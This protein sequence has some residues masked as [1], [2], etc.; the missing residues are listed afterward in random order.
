MKNKFRNLG[1]QFVCGLLILLWVLLVCCAIGCFIL[2]V[3]LITCLDFRMPRPIP[4]FIMG[5]WLSKLSTEAGEKMWNGGLTW[6]MQNGIRAFLKVVFSHFLV[7]LAAGVF[8]ILLAAFWSFIFESFASDNG[9]L[10][11]VKAFVMIPLVCLGIYVIVAAT[12][13]LWFRDQ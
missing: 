2:P 8:L 4:F 7:L 9:Q 5:W 11:M 1:R 6:I 12:A 10:D 13:W 3:Y